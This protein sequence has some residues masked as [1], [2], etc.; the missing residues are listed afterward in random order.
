MKIAIAQ[1]GPDPAAADGTAAVPQDR[2]H[3]DSDAGL[4]AQVCQGLCG[5]LPPLSETEIGA[6]RNVTSLQGV[7]QHAAD[8]I[9][10]AE[11]CQCLIKR[12]QDELGDAE[13]FQQ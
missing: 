4:L 10:G 12:H 8:K 2:Q 1:R 11:L 9:L 6:H 13:G 5:S 7:N 3:A